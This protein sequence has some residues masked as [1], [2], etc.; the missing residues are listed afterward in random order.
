MTP[1]RRL[2]MLERAAYAQG[3]DALSRR[4]ADRLKPKTDAEIWA[5]GALIENHMKT[6]EAPDELALLIEELTTE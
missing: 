4:I 1:E 5:I 3:H 2:E 6:G